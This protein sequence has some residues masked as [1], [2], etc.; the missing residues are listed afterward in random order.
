MEEI[1]HHLGWL[2]AYKKW[3]RPPINWC[4][5]FPSTVASNNMILWG[6]DF[7]GPPDTT[8]FLSYPSSHELQP[9][10]RLMESTLWLCQN[11]Y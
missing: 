8:W 6:S 4:R 2:K 11:S 3:D 9:K 7:R 5:I 1:L 10:C